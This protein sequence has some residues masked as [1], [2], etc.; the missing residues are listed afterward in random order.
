MNLLKSLT[1]THV[2]LNSLTASD[3]PPEVA[4][5]T[6]VEVQINGVWGDGYSVQGGD[7]YIL[8][9]EA[10]AAPRGSCVEYELKVTCE[11]TATDVAENGTEVCV[12]TQVTDIAGLKV[13][14]LDENNCPTSYM[15]MEHL[16]A[17]LQANLTPVSLCDQITS[18]PDVP[19]ADMRV[20]ALAGDCTLASIPL[21]GLACTMSEPEAF[22]CE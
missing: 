4:T 5:G 15:S 18:K 20:L 6:Q 11:D 3:F 14:V 2:V 16:V 22:S 19:T 13:A 9:R 1:G 12:A 21:E 8:M 10:I 7:W 17:Y